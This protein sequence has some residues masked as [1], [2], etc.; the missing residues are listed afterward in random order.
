MKL[1][2]YVKPLPKFFSRFW[3][4]GFTPM[5]FKIIFLR[6]EI[7]DNLKSN[8]P[9]IQNLSVL[10][11]EEIHR[12]RGGM[13]KAWRYLFPKLQ[14]QEELIAYK[15]Q[16]KFLKE[17]KETYNLENVAKHL[18]GIDYQIAKKLIAKVWNEA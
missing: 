10:K 2:Q 3:F 17:N 8:N 7:F 12:K 13:L 5:F 18:P 1:P 16:F 15:E 4:K 9:T 11:H 6:R 14:L